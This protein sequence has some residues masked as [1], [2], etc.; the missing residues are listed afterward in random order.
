MRSNT[1]AECGSVRLFPAMTSKSELRKAARQQRK[2]L[3]H[4]DIAAALAVHAGALA[5]SPGTIVGGYH[6]FHQEADPALLLAALVSAGCHVAFPRI[7]EKDAAL[8]FHLVPDGEVL[9]PG[10]HG[11]HEPQSHWPVVSPDILLVP[12]LAF[13]ARGHRL[14][15][16][17]GYY[18]RTLFQLAAGG[19]RPHAIG[20]AYAGQQTASL[21]DEAHDMA[22]DGVLTEGGLTI[23]GAGSSQ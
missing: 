2:L 23:F 18:D 1:N 14:G 12:L 15:Y 4:P 6:A 9:T 10:A 13:D 7:M 11:I 22:L 5:L 17:G 8:E 3:A 19:K 16:G 20:I 21:P